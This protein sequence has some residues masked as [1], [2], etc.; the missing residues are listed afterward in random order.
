MLNLL[1]LLG[2][3]ALWGGSTDWLPSCW[4]KLGRYFGTTVSLLLIAF[5]FVFS[6]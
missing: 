3:A 1:G 2:I 5:Y 4:E 6:Q